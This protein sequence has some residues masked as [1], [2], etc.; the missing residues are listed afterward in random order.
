[1]LRGFLN[2]QVL[3]RQFAPDNTLL[4]GLEAA[5]DS[6]S[7]EESTERLYLPAERYERNAALE[8]YSISDEEIAPSL[9]EL[10]IDAGEVVRTHPPPASDSQLIAIS[11]PAPALDEAEQR[12]ARPQNTASAAPVPVDEKRP[13]ETL[14][15]MRSAMRRARIEEIAPETAKSAPPNLDSLEEVGVGSAFPPE[16]SVPSV[17][18]PSREIEPQQPVEPTLLLAQAEIAY[19]EARREDSARTAPA[20]PGSAD[21]DGLRF[22]DDPAARF[23]EPQ[24]RYSEQPFFEPPAERSPD[25]AAQASFNQSVQPSLERA[26]GSRAEADVE[27]EG[28]AA[29]GTRVHTAKNE[30][31]SQE[32]SGNVSPR[33]T[34]D[35]AQAT[36]DFGQP[37]TAPLRAP[38]RREGADE[39][40]S[41]RSSELT[42]Q[43]WAARLAAATATNRA[44]AETQQ[45]AQPAPSASLSRSAVAPRTQN[46]RPATQPTAPL[47]GRARR[48]LKPL[49][50]FDPGAV[51]VYRNETAQKASE[52]VNADA[53][54]IGGA[55][56]MGANAKDDSPEALGLAAHELTHVAR[57]ASPRFV[58]P[59]AMPRAD[60]NAQ[61][62][63]VFAPPSDEEGLA[64][65]VESRVRRAARAQQ[66]ADESVD[67]PTFPKQA[68]EDEP[69]AG[70][71]ASAQLWSGVP[72]PWEPLPDWLA[73]SPAAGAAALTI[74]FGPASAPVE[75]ADG[76]LMHRAAAGRD[77]EESTA[78]AGATP[79]AAPPHGAPAPDLDALSYRVYAI[80][81]RRLAAER[82]REG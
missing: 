60:S 40:F 59:V 18:S 53:V 51:P 34:V 25:A 10:P 78:E 29:D 52:S 68:D 75:H 79:P 65:N 62:V 7:G 58:P 24:Q 45:S 22:G 2:R 56:F 64:L 12:S 23:L 80:L 36:A 43:D 66:T 72:A 70:H 81:K 48:F 50:G 26:D 5:A 6:L 69:G 15:Q 63:A 28:A 74:G 46:E 77:V 14:P 67:V 42:P 27:I 31:R 3:L 32:H 19:S 73:A 82:R 8:R 30:P 47:S 49:M 54:T 38:G 35:R 1:M 41:P 4:A 44:P 76:P 39:L 71:T 33:Q 11:L 13:R 17:L 16:P 21:A 55:V 20:S 57:Q 9:D 61:Q 37:E